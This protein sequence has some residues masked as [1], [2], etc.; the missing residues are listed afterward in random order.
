MSRSL[1]F[2]VSAPGKVILFGE[3]SVLYAEPAL[4]TAI[5]KRTTLKF[6]LTGNDIVLDFKTVDLFLQ[7]SIAEVNTLFANVAAHKTNDDH[8]TECDRFIANIIQQNIKNLKACESY[9]ASQQVSLLCVFYL[10]YFLIYIKN[11]EIIPFKI[12]IISELVTGAGTGS[13]ASFS[14][15]LATA[16]NRYSEFISD[17]N[18]GL[19]VFDIND[20]VII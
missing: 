11:R 1:K 12:E 13:S 6:E 16:L 2:S 18:F 20:E 4:A 3:H 7:I 14:V 8:S 15:C 10:L 17:T 9:S 5:D 19:N